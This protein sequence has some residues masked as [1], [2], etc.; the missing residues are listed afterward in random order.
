MA[1]P[2]ARGRTQRKQA[3]VHPMPR[4]LRQRAQDWRNHGS[5]YVLYTH[6]SACDSLKRFD[7]TSWLLR[8]DD[9]LKIARGR[10]AGSRQE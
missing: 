8:C 4:Q 2:A 10:T 1:T 7:A 5:R 6:A 9:V 3:Q